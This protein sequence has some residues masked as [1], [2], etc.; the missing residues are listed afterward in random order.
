LKRPDRAVVGAITEAV[1][2]YSA[3]ATLKPADGIDVEKNVVE[4]SA[5]IQRRPH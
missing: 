1:R 3:A 5:A 4:L 2:R